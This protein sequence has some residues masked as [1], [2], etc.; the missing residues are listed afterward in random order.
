M[1]SAAGAGSAV[2]AP[3]LPELAAAAIASSSPAVSTKLPTAPQLLP[4]GSHDTAS[5]IARGEAFAT[6]GTAT[7]LACPQAGAGG[8]PAGASVVSSA[9][10]RPAVSTNQPIAA[11]SEASEQETPLSSPPVASGVKRFGPSEGVSIA[12]ACSKAPPSSLDTIASVSE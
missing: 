3:K 6:G 2:A 1:P 12:S 7:S 10:V 9:S 5:S 11:Q 8:E 4:P